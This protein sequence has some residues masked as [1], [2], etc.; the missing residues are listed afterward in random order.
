MILIGIRG[1]VLNICKRFPSFNLQDLESMKAKSVEALNT[2]TGELA[3]TYHSLANM[4]EETQNQL[5]KE[6]FLF[7]DDDP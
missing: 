5:V 3:G 1:I 4:D 2:L 7:R 6:H